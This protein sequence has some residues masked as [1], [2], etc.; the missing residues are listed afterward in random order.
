MGDDMRVTVIATGFNGNNRQHLGSYRSNNRLI[1]MVEHPR[2]DFDVPTFQRLQDEVNS[3]KKEEREIEEESI[4]ENSKK[5]D[6][7]VPAYLRR[8]AN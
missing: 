4:L 7:D 6:Y 8:R 5:E 2:T 1:E 3:N